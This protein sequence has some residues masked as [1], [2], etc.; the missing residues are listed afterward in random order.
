MNK[1]YLEDYKHKEFAQIKGYLSK[2]EVG[3]GI[4]TGDA[5]VVYPQKSRFPKLKEPVA[6]CGVLNDSIWP[7]I[8]LFGSLILPV[9]PATE[10]FLYTFWGITKREFVELIDFS[11]KTGKVQFVLNGNIEDYIDL[12]Y[13]SPLFE[14]INPPFLYKFPITYLIEEEKLKKYTQIFETLIQISDQKGND[15]Y[16]VI[17][18]VGLKQQTKFTKDEIIRENLTY[19]CFLKEFGYDEILE[20]FEELI[21]MDSLNAFS[22]LATYGW[23]IVDESLNS[24]FNH[25]VVCSLED[26]KEFKFGSLNYSRISEVGKYLLKKI[27]FMPESFQA[28]VDV[29]SRYNQEDLYNVAQSLQKAVI[30]SDVDSFKK[31]KRKSKLY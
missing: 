8:P 22:H 7:Q 17:C 25:E 14:E 5:S 6:L 31:K 15:I 12:D 19:Y 1:E 29:I 3:R 23:L 13:L 26:L 21:L 28:C 11:K 18:G 4:P 30:D 20:N 2:L 16:D 10:K 27:T 24:M 9:P